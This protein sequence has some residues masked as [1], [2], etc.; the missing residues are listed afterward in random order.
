M[1]WLLAL[2]AILLLGTGLLVVCPLAIPRLRGRFWKKPI[3]IMTLGGGLLTAGSALGLSRLLWDSSYANDVTNFTLDSTMLLAYA[4]IF[5]GLIAVL[6]GI[7]LASLITI[8]IQGSSEV[9]TVTLPRMFAS[10]LRKQVVDLFGRQSAPMIVYSLGKRMGSGF[11]KGLFKARKYD[12]EVYAKGLSEIAVFA[13]W[14]ENA[15]IVEYVPGESIVMR[16]HG[17]METLDGH[18]S[19][20]PSCDFA[21]GTLAGIVEGL[22]TGVSVEAIETKCQSKGDSYCEFTANIYPMLAFQ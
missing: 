19:S 10:D 16:T 3:R 7:S 13:S 22:F 8:Q 5:A 17:N 21:R 9:G 12:P 11:A 2:I 20:V 18:S 4:S 6:V 14:S 15:E 1:E